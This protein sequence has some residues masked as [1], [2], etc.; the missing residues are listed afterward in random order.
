[1]LHNLKS[2]G[3]K[4]TSQIV[5]AN[6]DR[7]AHKLIDSVFFRAIARYATGL[8]KCWQ[9]GNE[10]SSAGIQFKCTKC[11]I[12]LELPNDVVWMWAFSSFLPKI[13]LKLNWLWHWYLF[14]ITFNCYAL[15]ND[16]I[17]IRKHWLNNFDKFRMYYIPI[18]LVI[19]KLKKLKISNLWFQS[20]FFHFIRIFYLIFKVTVLFFNC[21]SSEKEQHLSAEWSSLVNKAYKILLSP[22]QRAEYMLKSQNIEVS[23]NNSTS[24]KQFLLDMMERNEEVN[25]SKK[26]SKI[27]NGLK[28]RTF[29]Q[30]GQKWPSAVITQIF[31]GTLYAKSN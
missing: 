26:F 24:N 10:N 9:C 14:R 5:V 12:L 30:L 22:I 20:F 28:M 31:F 19:G 15:I 7:C 21:D 29:V 23:E 16:L 11:Q 1:M 3:T 17:S 4:R 25:K 13:E 27:Y 6:S 2:V 18:S 8:I